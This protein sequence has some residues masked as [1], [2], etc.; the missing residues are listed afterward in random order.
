MVE[1]Y[2]S[3]LQFEENK[4][5]QDEVALGIDLG[6]TN[7]CAVVWHNGKYETIY[8]DQ[9]NK[10]TPSVVQ[11]K[12]DEIIVGEDA[13]T[14]AEKIESVSNIIFGAKRLIGRKFEDATVQA[15][16]KHFPFEIKAD[17]DGKP[18]YEI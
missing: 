12:G 16:L 14:N 6:T 2:S 7:S 17:S 18:Q 11:Y 8:N 1:K 15:D 9:G 5:E 4:D 3:E 10:T 13:K